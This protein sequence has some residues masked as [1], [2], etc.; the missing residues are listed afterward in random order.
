MNAYAM[1]SKEMWQNYKYDR[2]L[3][4]DAGA[5][6]LAGMARTIAEKW[7]SLSAESRQAFQERAKEARSRYKEE[8]QEYKSS[9]QGDRDAQLADQRYQRR[10]RYQRLL[11]NKGKPTRPATAFTLFFRDFYQQWRQA[12]HVPSTGVSAMK[13]AG[14]KWREMAESDRKPY[15]DR[16]AELKAFYHQNLAAWKQATSKSKPSVHASG[17]AESTMEQPPSDDP[18]GPTSPH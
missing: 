5:V 9:I 7:R 2:M 10:L 6:S 8:M 12:G 14:A 11:R 3:S 18:F 4:G 15:T 1:F 17:N 16:A 13:E